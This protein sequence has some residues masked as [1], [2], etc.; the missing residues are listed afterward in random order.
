MR[1]IIIFIYFFLLEL[2]S[3]QY[4]YNDIIID[5]PV[6][7][8]NSGNS[9]LGAGYFKIIN[10][11]KNK[12]SLHGIESVIA[13]KQQIHEVI[14]E[15]DIYKMRPIKKPVHI[16]SGNE[17]KFKPKSYHVM[18]YN[19]KK[20]HILNEMLKAK[21]LFNKNVEIDIEFKVLIGNEEHKHH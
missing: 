20:S 7:K 8:M 18:F 1:Y 4:E 13:E 10:N 14:L 19:I 21:I 11:S 2:H 15:N 3:H 6:L 12:I 9:K 17:L 16:L 5:H